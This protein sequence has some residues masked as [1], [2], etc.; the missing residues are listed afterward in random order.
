[1]HAYGVSWDSLNYVAFGNASDHPPVTLKKAKRIIGVKNFIWA[2]FDY[3]MGWLIIKKSY[4]ILQNAT[5]WPIE[6]HRQ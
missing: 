2:R 1:M 4:R 5:F 3:V 6:D